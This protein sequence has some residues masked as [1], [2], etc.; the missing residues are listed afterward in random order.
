MEKPKK[1]FS[2]LRKGNSVSLETGREDKSAAQESSSDSDP[3]P[4]PATTLVK[5][6][7]PLLAKTIDA[8][9]TKYPNSND[10]RTLCEE[11]RKIEFELERVLDNLRKHV[12]EVGSR[13]PN[14]VLGAV[15]DI[16]E[17]L[18]W[19]IGENQVIVNPYLYPFYQ[20]LLE[21]D[22]YIFLVTGRITEHRE[23]TVQQMETLGLDGYKMLFCKPRLFY[24]YAPIES[25]RN[26][27]SSVALYKR[28]I[29]YHI[30]ALLD[31]LLILNA[32]D[33]LS[34]LAGDR[35]SPTFVYSNQDLLL[36]ARRPSRHPN[37]EFCQVLKL[38]NP[39]YKIH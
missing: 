18:V 1:S 34:D 4:V 14:R 36:D 27:L 12:L 8:L 21:K 2:F 15:F 10:L 37:L 7:D 30:A 26:S 16:D 3:S 35:I 13:Y 23:H 5:P 33:Q 28:N 32:G 6:R 17:T 25:V 39:F 24:G 9:I 29:R 11:Y 38:I 19:R 31:V 22:V 20:F